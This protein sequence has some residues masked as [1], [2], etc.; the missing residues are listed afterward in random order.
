MINKPHT[1]VQVRLQDGRKFIGHVDT[2]DVSSDLA[3]IR[4][5]ENEAI[6]LECK[7][8]PVLK[9]GKSSDLRAGEWVLALGSPLALNNT[10]T[11]GV[12]SSPQRASKELGIQG[13]KNRFL[14]LI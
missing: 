8:L 12:I 2:V 13:I 11:S 14:D 4:I 10:V 6:Q 3:T 7:N 9:L 5:Y 1:F